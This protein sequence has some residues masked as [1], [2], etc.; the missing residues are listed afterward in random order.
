MRVQRLIKVAAIC[1]IIGLVSCQDAESRL[2]N[3]LLGLNNIEL[4]NSCWGDKYKDM[5]LN[6]IL[7]VFSNDTI[8]LPTVFYSFD[9]NGLI[10]YDSMKKHPD[11]KPMWDRQTDSLAVV[12]QQR[13]KDAVGTW[14]IISVSPDS[15]YIYAPNHPMHGSYLVKFFYDEDGWPEMNAPN[16][17]Y[18]F[19]LLNEKDQK[20]F[21]LNKAGLLY[22][23]KY[24]HWMD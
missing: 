7:V 2:H 21:V 3:K 20:F 19:T 13:L 8:I 6:S 22:G 12:N 24:K 14:G 17:K 18:K 16:N 10:H 5:S 23:G 9:T 1:G 11:L 4:E 15:I